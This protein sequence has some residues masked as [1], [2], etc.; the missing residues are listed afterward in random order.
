MQRMDGRF[1]SFAKEM[2]AYL[3]AQAEASPHWRP[4]L[5][6][7]RTTG[8]MVTTY[9]ETATPS[10]TSGYL[11]ELGDKT[12]ALARRSGGQRAADGGPEAGLTGMGGAPS[13]WPPESIR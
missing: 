1:P 4:T 2:I 6:E 9:D 12:I 7:L 11:H 13:T 10:G 5:G 3:G 8:E